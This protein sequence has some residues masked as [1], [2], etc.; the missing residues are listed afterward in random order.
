MLD[1]GLKTSPGIRSS[2]L[3]YVLTWKES[4]F[5][6][7]H[8][9]EAVS[10]GLVTLS[11]QSTGIKLLVLLNTSVITVSFCLH[12]VYLNVG[13]RFHSVS[14]VVWTLHSL[15]GDVNLSTSAMF[16]TFQSKWLKKDCWECC[17]PQPPDPEKVGSIFKYPIGVSKTFGWDF[18]ILKTPPHC[19]D[20]LFVFRPQTCTQ[21]SPLN[22]ACCLMASRSSGFCCVHAL[23]NLKS[24][25]PALDTEPGAA[26]PCIHS[27]PAAWSCCSRWTSS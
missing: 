23:R 27:V 13:K 4:Q 14:Y 19:F 21:S 3:S 7:T 2:Y 16:T 26:V 15:P 20:C 5:C 9:M 25:G 10:G 24:S 11:A 12:V 1:V 8:R 6:V 17:L 22:A 18:K